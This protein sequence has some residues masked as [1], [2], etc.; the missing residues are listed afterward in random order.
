MYNVR[1]FL[2]FW[3]DKGGGGGGGGGG[4][5][6]LDKIHIISQKETYQF[7]LPSFVLNAYVTICVIARNKKK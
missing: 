1:S 3:Q 5:G 6:S 7:A 2:A 4:M